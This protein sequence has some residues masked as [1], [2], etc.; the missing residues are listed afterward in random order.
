MTTDVG[1][2][3]LT[4]AGFLM[5]LGALIAIMDR[6]ESSLYDAMATR[7]DGQDMDAA[8][9]VSHDVPATLPRL[10][11]PRRQREASNVVAAPPG[12]APCGH[13]ER[14]KLV[15]SSTDHGECLPAGSGP[16][17]HAVGTSTGPDDEIGL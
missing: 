7:L 4:I 3:L 10:P 9:A 16:V 8:A 1:H 12:R 6:V 17:G 13:L 5:A 14:P 2:V 15:V 11:E